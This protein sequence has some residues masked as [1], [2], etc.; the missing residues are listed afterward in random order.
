MPGRRWWCETVWLGDAEAAAA[1]DLNLGDSTT[2]W[3]LTLD[4]RARR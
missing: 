2:K 4:E 1:R 3:G